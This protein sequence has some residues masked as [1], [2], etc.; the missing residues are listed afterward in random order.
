LVLL[1]ANEGQ[2]MSGKVRFAAGVILVAYVGMALGCG[3]VVTPPFENLDEI[4]HLDVVRYIVDHGRLPVHGE[5]EAEAYHY[6]QE[7]YQPPLYHLLSAGIARFLGLRGDDVAAFVRPNPNLVCGPEPATPYDNRAMFYHDPNREGCPWTG[8]LLMVHTLR[9]WSIL[10]QAITVIGTYGLARLALPKRREVAVLAMAIVAFNPEFLLVASSV[11]NDNLVTPL[12]TVGLCLLL[13]IEQKG[14]TVWRALG[15]GAVIGLA[16]LSKLSGW[17]LMVPGG[18]L[19]VV[20]LARAE[21]E[22]ERL[23]ISAA[24]V[25]AMALLVAGWWFW[26]NHRL[27]SDLTGLRPMLE[28]VGMRTARILPLFE[29]KLMFRSFWGQIPCSPFPSAFY[30]PYSLLT[31]LACIG[32]VWGGREHSTRERRQLII[33]ASWLLVVTLGWIRWDVMTPAPWGRL[34]F[35]A[36][37]AI[38]VMMAVGLL[39]WCPRTRAV[40]MWVAVG[41]L[42]LVAAW[43]VIWILPAFFSPPVRHGDGSQVQTDHP[44]DVRFGEDIGLAGYDVSMSDPGR[45]L[46]LTLY[47]LAEGRPS[48]DYVLVLQLVSLVPGDNSLL[49]NYRAWPGRGNYPTSAWQA[50]E[51]IVDRYRVRL[52]QLGYPTQAWGLHVMLIRSADDEW[53]PVRV[54][55]TPFGDR[56]VLTRVRVSGEPPQCQRDAHLASEVR[57]GD[58]AALTHESVVV[59]EE[60]TVVTLC[61][62][63][64][65]PT[66]TDYTVFVHLVDEDGE[67]VETADAPPMQGAFP[68]SE[69]LAGD[70][71]ADVHRLSALAGG[72]DYGITVGMY[73][74]V[75]GSRLPAACAEEPVEDEVAL[76]WPTG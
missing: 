24:A 48:E 44:L 3:L 35:P 76:L 2:G 25:P 60:E 4:E 15:L 33:L 14:L 56:L 7:V 32:L 9:I 36:L 21:E 67:L 58:V 46:D 37:P 28:V 5:D 38:G 39:T 29:A 54:G 22:L 66:G 50:G 18:L 30:A 10:L 45:T 19:V 27:Y 47:W 8:A 70:V 11:T 59:G 65:L 41:V 51:V 49:W 23:V 1:F 20:L 40:R 71:I 43:S 62:Q 53:L 69:W 57:F 16:G 12:A 64:L 17:L 26:R 75:D 42:A 31:V 68:T 34:L 73:N 72:P 61:W 55:G 13:R 52:P 63:S 6:R 74:P